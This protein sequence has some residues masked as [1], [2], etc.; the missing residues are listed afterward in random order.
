MACQLYTENDISALYTIVHGEI[1]D[2]IQ[3]PKLGK[4]DNKTLDKF[5]KEIYEEF[6]DE[7]NGL[8]Y[9]QAV[10]DIL[11]L[12][13]NDLEI[14][15]YLVK[16]SGPTFFN[17]IQELSLDF[18]DENNVLKFVSTKVKQPTEKEIKKRIIKGNKSSKNIV[19]NT[20]NNQTG[21]WSAVQEKAKVAFPDGTSFQIA[22][23]KNPDLLTE[24]DKNKKDP[25]KK[26]FDLIIKDLIRQSHNRDANDVVKIGDTTVM[27]KAQSIKN[28]DKNDL[29]KSDLAFLSKNKNYNITIAIV[30]DSKG[31]SLRFDENGTIVED[32]GRIVYQYIRPVIRSDNKLYL[33]NRSKFL[34]NLISAVDLA[35]KQ[36]KNELKD[37]KMY[38][39]EER[40]LLVSQIKNQQIQKMN[41]LERLNEA[42]SEGTDF[43][44]LPIT[45]GSYG[46]LEKKSELLSNT[47]FV[48]SINMIYTHDT[49]DLKGY[50]FFQ[51]NKLISG[52]SVDNRIYLQKMDMTD[53]IANNIAKV[54]TT[55]ALL[56]GEELSSYDRLVY[57]ENFLSN[58][59]VSNK[60]NVEIKEELGLKVLSVT[61]I[62]PITKEQILIDL[63][64]NDS[65]KL[66]SDHLKAVKKFSDD[67]GNIT[68]FYPASMSYM[69]SFS[70]DGAIQKGITFTEYEFTNNKNNVEIIKEVKKDY[71]AFIKP[72]AK[73]DYTQGSGSYIAGLNSYLKFAIPDDLKTPF[74]QLIDIGIDKE[75]N[76]NSDDI[77]NGTEDTTKS[78]VEEEIDD[79]TNKKFSIETSVSS[80]TNEKTLVANI[81]SSNIVLGLGLG[82][83]TKDEKVVLNRAGTENKWYGIK[84]GSKKN[85]PKNFMPS[86]TTIDQMI[87]NLSKMKGG[88]INI[89][90]NDISQLSKDGYTQKDINTYI[91]NILKGVSDGFTITK[92]ISN[93][94]TG[95]AEASIIAAKRLG[96]PVKIRAFSGYQL[97]K[98]APYLKIGYKVEK[99]TKAEFL[100]RFVGKSSKTYTKAL[101]KISTTNQDKTNTVPIK[102]DVEGTAPNVVAKTLEENKKTD[103]KINNL[104]SDDLLAGSSDDLFAGL[105]R[106][107]RVAAVM[108][109]LYGKDTTWND[110]DKWWDSSP[111]KK[112]TKIE[113]AKLATVFNSTAYGTFLTSGAMLSSTM[114]NLRKE[115]FV[116]KIKLYG[117]AL[118]IT[119]YH[120]AW[121]AFS[122]L[123]LTIDEKTKLYNEIRTYDK[124]AN[125]EYIEIEEDLAEAFIDYVVNDKKQKGFIQTIFDKIKQLLNYFFKNTN[126]KDIARLQDIPSVKMYFEKLHTNNFVIDTENAENNLMPGFH[127]LNSSKNT[128]QTIKSE[129]K[130]F[131]EIT[132]VQS[133]KIVNVIDSLFARTFRQYNTKFNTTSGAIRLLSETTNRQ[134]LYANVKKQLEILLDNQI[135]VVAKIELKNLDVE[136]ENPDFIGEQK[137]K[138]K[139]DLLTKAIANYGDVDLS[140]SKKTNKGVVSFHMKNSRFSVLKDSYVDDSEDAVSAIFKTTEGNSIS[141]KDLATDDTMMML[142]GIYLL[143]RNN[144]GEYVIEK[145]EDGLE[146]YSVE[147]DDFGLPILESVNVM[148]NKVARAMQGSMDY[149]DMHDRLVDSVPNDPEFIQILEMLPN[150]YQFGPAA[151]NNKTEFHS[152]TNFWQDLKKPVIPYI[153][154]TINKTIVDKAKYIDG[155]FIRATSKYESRLAAANF[156]IYRILNDWKT[157]FN[158][159]DPEINAYITRDGNNYLNVKKIIEDFSLNNRLDPNK[160]YDFL[161]AM[162]IQLDLTSSNIRNIVKDTEKPFAS[163]YNIDY[164]YNNVKLVYQA[165]ISNDLALNNA[166]E[167]FKKNPLFYLQEGLPKVIEDASGG[168]STDTRSRILTLAQLQNR[169]S[170]GYSNYSVLT[171]EKNKVWEVFLD[172]QVTRIVTSLNRAKN[173]QQLTDDN[174]DPNGRFSHMRWLNEFNNPASQFSVTL[175]SIFNLDPMSSTYGEKIPGSE[176]LLE[177]IGGTQIV[178]KSSNESIGASTASTDVTS[179]FLQE[180]HTMLQS[181]VQE[182][183]RHASKQTAMNLRASKLN[184]YSGKKA[185][186]LYVDVMSF[187]PSNTI[188]NNNLGES[189][190]FNVILGYISAEAGRIYRFK[191]DKEYFKNFSSYNRETIRKDTG[192]KA[193]VGEVFTAFDDVISPSVQGELYKIIDE[194]IE[195]SKNEQLNTGYYDYTDFNFKDIINEDPELRKRIKDDVIAYFNKQSQQNYSRLLNANYVDPTL[196]EMVTSDELSKTQVDK[197]LIKAYTYNSWIHNF[198]TTILVYGDAVQFDHDKEEFHKRNASVGSGGRSFRADYRARMFINSPLY[199]NLYAEKEGY[200]IEAYNGTLNTAIIKEEIIKESVYKPEYFDKHVEDYTK[201]YIDS[202]KSKKEATRLAKELATI[203]LKDYSN[204]KIADGQGWINFEAYKMLKNL[205]GNWSQKQDDLYKRIVNEDV[206]SA[207]EIKE[208]FPPYKLQYSGNIKVNGLPLNSFHKFSLAPL[209]PSVHTMDTR[210]GQIH[211]MMLSQN[212]HYVLMETGEKIGHFGNGDVITDANGNIDSSVVLTKNVIFAEFLKNQTEI[213]PKYKKTSIFSTQLRKLV[214]EGVYEQGEIINKNPAVQKIITD[215]IDR[216]S[217]YTELLTNKLVDELGFEENEDGE[218]IPI[219]KDSIAKLALLIRENLTRDDVYSDDLVDIIDVTDSGE[220]RFDL[221]LHPEANKIEKLLLSLI[222]KTII[223]QKVKGEPLVQ[224]SSAFYD[225][226]FELNLDIDKMSP[227]ARDAAVKKYMGSNF[228]PTYHVSKNG[229]TAA[230][231]VAIS[232]QGDYESLLNLEYK[233]EVIGD[234][235]KLNEAVKDDEW[236]DANN[237]ANRKAITMVGVRIPVQGLN[238]MEFMEIYHFLPAEAGNIII[239]P[240]EIVAKSGADFDIDKLSIFMNNIDAE[241]KIM[242][243]MFDNSADFYDAI[244]DPSKYDMTKDQMY[245]MQKA[246]LENLLIND[247]KS[248]LELPENFVSL[249]TPNSTYLV[250]PLADKLSEFVMEYN[251]FEN[252]ILNAEGKIV[253]NKDAS[254]KNVISPTRIFEVGYNLYKHESNIVGKKTLGL[255]AIENTFNVIYNSLGASMPP[256]YFHSDEENPRIASLALRHHKMKKNGESVISL[257]NKFDVDGVTKIADVIAQLINGWVDVEKDAWIFFIQGNYE[258]AP[259]LLYLLKTGV[260]VQEAVYF[261]SQPLVLEYVKEKRLTTSTYAE[262]LRRDPGYQGVD[263]TAASNIISKNFKTFIPTNESRYEVGVEM[264]NNYFD[265]KNR[266]DDNRNFTENEMLSLIEESKSN[267]NAPKSELS[268]AMFLHYL[269]IEQQIQG[270]TKLKIASN[271][272][273]STLTDV[274]QAIQAESNMDDLAMETKIDQELRTKML[275]DS[276]ISSF[277]NTK[278]IKGLSKPLFK[279]RYDE[280]IQEY[281][282]EY[283]NDFTNTSILKTAFGKNY[284]EIVPILFRNDLLSY[285]FQNTMRK[286]NLDKSY[287]SYSMAQSLTNTQAAGLKFGAQVVDGKDGPVLVYDKVQ[288]EKEFFDKSYLIG[289]DA[290]NNYE[291]RGLY[292]LEPGHFGSNTASNKQ[293]YIRFVIEREFLRYTMPFSE[294]QTS[295]EFKKIFESAQKNRITGDDTNNRRYAYEK[296]ISMRALDNTLNP[297]HLFND[298]DNSFAIRLER[299]KLQYKNDFVKEYPVLSRMVIDSNYNNTMFNIFVDDK[300]M[301]TFKANLYSKNIKNLS[302]KSIKKVEN[303]MEN[304]RISDFFGN[305]TYVAMMQS[306]INKNKYNFLNL[307]DFTKFI[308]I[309]EGET[310]KF[311][312][313]GDKF[314]MIIDF[315]NKFEKENSKENLN[316]YRSKNF[317][318][319]L[320]VQTSESKVAKTT[321]PSTGIKGFKLSIDKKGK[322]Q[323]KADLANRFIGYGV[324]GTSTYQYQQDAKKAGIPLNYEGV[325]DEST[326]AFVSVNGNNKASEKAIYET[327]ENAREVLENGGTIVMDSTFDATRSWNQNGEALVQEGIGEPTG[328]TS[329]GY[330]YWGKNPEITGQLLSITP[331]TNIFNYRTM[332]EADKINAYENN[333]EDAQKRWLEEEI[334]EFYEAVYQYNNNLNTLSSKGVTKGKA[335]MDDIIDETLGVFRTAQIFPKFSNLIIPYLSDLKISLNSFD[336]KEGYAIYKAKKDAK[337]QAKDMT[338]EN[339]FKFV[340]KYITQPSTNVEITNN[341]EYTNSVKKI[342]DLNLKYETNK[343]NNTRVL[344]HRLGVGTNKSTDAIL[345]NITS[346]LRNNKSL[347]L[348][349]SAIPNPDILKDEYYAEYAPGED[350]YIKKVKNKYYKFNNEEKTEISKEEYIELSRE[351]EPSAVDE[352]SSYIIIKPGNKDIVWA[353]F[354][355]VQ[356]KYVET[357]KGLIPYLKESSINTIVNTLDTLGNESQENL[358]SSLMGWNEVV[359]QVNSDNIVKIVVNNQELNIDDVFTDKINADESSAENLVERKNLITTINP[360]VF[361]YNDLSGSEKA[362]NYIVENNPD[363]T[364]VYQFSLGQKQAIDKM[365][366]AQFNSKKMKGNIQIRKFAN[367]SSVGI[368]TGQDSVAD[369]FSKIDSNLYPKRKADIEKAISEIK[370][371]VSKGGKVAFSINGYGD[372]TLMPEEL[373]VY[374]SERLFEE[375]QYLNPGAEFI[376]SI[377]E[378]VS[379]FQL[380]TDQ[381]ILDK[382]KDENNP[383]KC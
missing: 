152:E 26:L 345:D 212:I 99:N 307:T 105:D 263:F 228:L 114:D 150:P 159:S 93:G 72:L 216:V 237:G 50:S 91:Y 92:I 278:L 370:D 290:Q 321:Q 189:Q 209:I 312:T 374:L 29:T 40:N 190:A 335:T 332:T 16:E 344:I 2:R 181:G 124:W 64:S 257:S 194:Y 222:N 58:Q 229:N 67:S 238:S 320:N 128:I 8:L 248:I 283:V 35:E 368:I 260:P 314:K 55:K 295:E 117:D 25:D 291:D 337:N 1:M 4:F 145:D 147:T 153:Q 51:T 297:Y 84:I 22:E 276:I 245:N 259:I 87:T 316:K 303:E 365:T 349:T 73:V 220:L 195:D 141:S 258:V 82:F 191:S 211:D 48:D 120:E 107:K 336:K 210:L 236:L 250:K 347:Y 163:R 328:Q 136:N 112:L 200:T 170:D 115:G 310:A 285:I 217:E 272:D 318:T 11:D 343:F 17:Y 53:A 247:I 289:S 265:N 380:I 6:K 89:V 301:N 3:D 346:L 52:M 174:A 219:N 362:Y 10:P 352:T 100:S 151:Y 375:F 218:Y 271:P 324:S 76:L 224:K 169:Y 78:V 381:E 363:I 113:R 230:M 185:S 203:V 21:P 101:S 176:L 361:V 27:L 14:K 177:N 198:E 135:K 164:I 139:L 205:E 193:K 369:A 155:K 356:S 32:G 123:V 96:I 275:N 353:S 23:E 299:I 184:T 267:P 168:K 110:V 34:Y 41:D 227:A 188:G 95:I 142:S 162:G 288:I 255:G 338:Y 206:I 158:I 19:V 69:K 13:K 340:D 183:M 300:D 249:T 118:P 157:N 351:Y 235:N 240:A 127:K 213:N 28:I 302:D 355:D 280:D 251:P 242:N 134:K 186:N 160:A 364:F 149:L 47:D 83:D 326:V 261:V 313:S 196:Y 325:I 269:T 12:V 20:N 273:T 371:I 262:V 74:D 294:I 59:V 119:L 173:W 45:G 305:I 233:G 306:G 382:F 282:Q 46:V 274:G 201:R 243:V 36:I 156:D 366:E 180:M 62:D 317:L 88:I 359:T 329:K 284:R 166:A 109:Q 331:K 129:A 167:D 65:E 103:F 253:N 360:D 137:E 246:G 350:R 333:N 232:L 204:M 279:F 85:A 286:Y 234:I 208:Y 358:K 311:L 56:N 197:L 182:F 226:L 24:A 54:L 143:Q 330:N 341:S 81:N 354:E 138:S 298:K 77:D 178:D 241:G 39:E 80:L 192:G 225:G 7:P 108:N 367:S 31:K 383:L 223:K 75:D 277:F 122:Q 18:E 327:I 202:G 102:D 5:I 379:K 348:S 357:S 30:S 90:G 68:Q 161:A 126:T 266:K 66:I 175:N 171:P 378:Q 319:A 287:N 37:G 98:S 172:N 133:D 270:N 373:F 44:L 132:D 207:S 104:S 70:V 304:D 15:K 221:S 322:D 339:L 49:G 376:N 154:L 86:Q 268:R 94:Q 63:E 315:K 131:S 215:Y 281:I 148:W 57:Y 293:E 244:K 61:L 60:I 296:I 140:L 187:S 97:R 372:P 239:P 125:K 214:L 254:G 130:G 71:F 111:L 264:L 308:D 33:G 9:A 106:N 377:N 256:F 144:D 121:H 231:K 146:T 42:L 38:D 309:M 116:A 79:E 199:Q 165:S 292:A 323:G 342:D 179:K 334:G 43:I 252:M